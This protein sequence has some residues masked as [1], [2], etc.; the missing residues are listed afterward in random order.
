MADNNNDIILSL[1]IPTNGMSE[2]VLPL[3]ESIYLQLYDEDKYEV[4]I[5]DNGDNSHLFDDIHE[6][7]YNHANLIYKKTKSPLFANQIECFK[8]AKGI[9]VKFINHRFILRQNSISE[10][11]SYVENNINEKPVLYFLNNSVNI[12]KSDVELSFNDFMYELNYYASW[13]GGSSFWKNDYS[14]LFSKSEYDKYFPHIDTVIGF[15]DTRKYVINNKKYFEMQKISDIKKGKYDLYDAFSYHFINLI[16]GLYADGSIYKKTYK[17]IRK[18]NLIFV[19]GLFF[20]YNILK[21]KCSYVINNF[22]F[23]FFKTY[24]L[25]DFIHGILYIFLKKLFL[26]LCL[27]KV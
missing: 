24:N 1:C 15:K 21:K 4:I 19:M 2:W 22:N 20:D 16:K 12:K 6:Y 18:K 23:Y 3:L 11:I 17:H 7:V 9:F 8:L 14:T 13:S 10:I 25:I 26:K 27:K 5:T